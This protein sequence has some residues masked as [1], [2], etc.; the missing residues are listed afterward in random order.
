MKPI[1][2]LLALTMGFTA[3]SQASV[4]TLNCRTEK[5][6]SLILVYDDYS[7][8]K[9]GAELISL[10]IAGREMGGQLENNHFGTSGG[11]PTFGI[12]DFPQA[13]LTTRFNIYSTG[14]YTVYKAGS[15][16]GDEH[17]ITCEVATDQPAKTDTSF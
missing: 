11:R 12:L 9:Q 16:S 13:G 8:A 15:F 17:Q 5:S 10:K 2:T 6:T 3:I 1:F 14:T 7:K 4:V